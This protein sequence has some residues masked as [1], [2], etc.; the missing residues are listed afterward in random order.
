MLARISPEIVGRSFLALEALTSQAVKLLRGEVGALRPGDVLTSVSRHGKIGLL[1]FSSMTLLAVRLG[2]SGRLVLREPAGRH[3]HLALRLSEG[4]TLTYADHRRFGAMYVW[5]AAEALSKPPLLGIGPDVLNPGLDL[6]LLLSGR[7]TIKDA[8][9]DQSIVAGLGNIYA[10][11]ALFRAGVDPRCPCSKVGL[12]ERHRLVA[13][14]RLLLTEAMAD[15]GATL[16]DYRGTEGE[17]GTFDTKFAVYGR[18]G[19]PCPGC[20]CDRS[21]VRIRQGGRSTW[22]CPTRQN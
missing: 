21:V 17:A 11:E 14:I 16:S 22:F 1:Y 7:R 15:R 3:D 10:C 6:G 12:E 8:L 19:H 9:L 20:I 5:P 4:R 18:E 13:E 2:M